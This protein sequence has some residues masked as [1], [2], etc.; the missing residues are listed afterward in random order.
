MNKTLV[1]AG[2]SYAGAQVAASVRELGYD[3]KV[4]LVG[5]EP[6]PPYHRPPLSKGFLSGDFAEER[7]PLRSQAFFDEEQ[8]HWIGSTRVTQVDRATKVVTLSNGESIS[9]EYL[10]LAT[11]ASVRKLTCPGAN[12]DR[13][14][15]LRNLDDA[16]RL[17]VASHSAQRAVVIGAGYIGLE[18]AASLRSRGLDVTV[19]EASPRP[20]GR[21]ASPWMSDFIVS[22][23]RDRGVKFELNRQIASIC[24]DS[25]ESV[26]VELAGGTHLACDLVVIGI[27]VSPNTDLAS[28]CGL[29]VSAGIV[30][31]ENLRT[32]DPAIFA[33]GDCVAF[34]PH[35]QTASES[36][37]RVESVQN[38]NDMGKSVAAAIT[39]STE[40]YRAVP[41]F[42]SDQFDI[43]LQMAGINTGFTKQVIRGRPDENRFSVFYFRDDKLIGVDSIN[44]PQDHMLARKL[45]TSNVSPTEEQA[46][47]TMF[48]LKTLLST[49]IGNKAAVTS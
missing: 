2:A 25:D 18:V 11:G 45:L 46:A 24:T 47:D 6:M 39:G 34:R 41:W 28:A 36:F 38:A 26:V 32:N 3:G 21:V 1:I 22:A 33:A 15:Y 14:H 44:K 13:I 9:Y 30:V 17:A 23:H 29:E 48:D 12:S 5:E 16:K 7:L 19:V 27:G 35:W 49:A 40:P 10:V 8:I 31:D 42:W 43:K 37:V 4:I 20:L